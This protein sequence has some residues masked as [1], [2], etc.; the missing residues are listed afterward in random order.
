[1]LKVVTQTKSKRLNKPLVGSDK[2]IYQICISYALYEYV[3][4]PL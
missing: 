2:I 1:M 3:V 4:I